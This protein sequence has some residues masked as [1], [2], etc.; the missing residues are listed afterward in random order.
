[1]KDDTK[2]M[3]RANCKGVGPLQFYAH[4]GGEHENLGLAEQTKRQFCDG[5]PVKGKCLE[6]ALETHQKHGVWGGMT[7]KERTN[8]R[9]SQAAKRRRQPG[10]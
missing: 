10:G 9:R 4:S 5:C 1:M 8:Y 7:E 2:W 6:Y 3:E